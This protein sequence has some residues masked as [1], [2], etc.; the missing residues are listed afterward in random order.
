MRNGFSRRTIPTADEAGKRRG[1]GGFFVEARLLDGCKFQ[2]ASFRLDTIGVAVSA[3]Y[4]SQALGIRAFLETCHLQLAA[5][6]D[7]PRFSGVKLVLREVGSKETWSVPI[8]C[9]L[10]FPLPP[11]IPRHNGIA[12]ISTEGA[13]TYAYAGW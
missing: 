8:C 12:P 10:P 2:V 7:R 1:L 11:P 3:A 5:N 4:R 6:G 13:S 9:T